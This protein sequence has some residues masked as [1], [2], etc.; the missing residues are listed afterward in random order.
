MKKQYIQPTLV[1]AYIDI[2]LLL[3]ESGVHSDDKTFIDYGGIDKEFEKDPESRR[4]NVW[5]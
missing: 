4:F 2:A 1:Q 3:T 5:E